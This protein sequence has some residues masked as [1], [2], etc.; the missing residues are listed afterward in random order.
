MQETLNKMVSSVRHGIIAPE[1]A[2]RTIHGCAAM[3]GLQ[4][5]ED[6]PETTLIVTGMRKMVE[7]GDVIEAFLEFGEIENAA[8]AP[9]A[10]GFGKFPVDS[11][12]FTVAFCKYS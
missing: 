11:H 9:N 3:L 6:I 4:L 2:S 12:L 5:A 8:V 10:R 1:E 7:R